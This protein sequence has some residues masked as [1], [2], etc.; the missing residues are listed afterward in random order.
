MVHAYK[1]ITNIIHYNRRRKKQ[2][3]LSWSS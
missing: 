1:Y 3:N 2:T